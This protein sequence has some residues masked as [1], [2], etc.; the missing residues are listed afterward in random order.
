MK[1]AIN[2]YYGLY[3]KTISNLNDYFYFTI[4]DELYQFK[5]LNINPKLL[6]SIYE[7]NLNMQ[8]HNI[9]VNTIIKNKYLSITTPINNT[10]YILYKIDINPQ[11]PITLSE[12]AYLSHQSI[13]YPESLVRSHW[14]ILWSNKIDYFEYQINELGKKHPYI[15]DSFSYFVG[16]AEN[17]ISYVKNTMLEVQ[18]EPSDTG[19][20]SHSTLTPQSTVYDLYNPENIIIDHKARDLA[21]YIKLSF[22]RNNNHIYD[23]LSHYFHHNYI[24]YYGMRLLFGRILYPSFYFHIYE[25]ILEDKKKEKELDS[26]INNTDTYTSYLYHIFIF[27]KKYYNIPEVEWLMKKK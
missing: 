22:F 23:E 25:E 24:S 13:P 27:L 1:N 26:I 3:P 18:P 15:V 19:V 16:M 17:A 10:N 21:E 9:L 4:N 5:P 14:D 2:Y 8:N 12:I 7:F 6:K 20:I 11:K